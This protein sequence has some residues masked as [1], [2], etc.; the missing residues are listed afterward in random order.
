LI[1]GV[2]YSRQQNKFYFFAIPNKAYAG[3]NQVEVI[4][5]SSTGYKEPI[6]IPKGKWTRYM[7]KDFATLATIT[8]DEADKL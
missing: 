3:C 4:L 1:R 7:V 2:G 6:G 5:D 8:P